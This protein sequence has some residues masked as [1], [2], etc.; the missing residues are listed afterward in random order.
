[1]YSVQALWSAANQQL[2]VIFVICNNGG[3]RILKQRLKAFHG[4]ERYIGMDFKD[5]AID[6]A[7]LARALGVPAHR[8]EDGAACDARFEEAL[9][10]ARP[11]LL[12]VVVDGTV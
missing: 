6:M 5:P 9:A 12:E 1:M 8:V 3:Y 11:T 7:G 4:D 10:S 2:P